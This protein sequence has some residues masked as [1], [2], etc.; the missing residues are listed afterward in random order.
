MTQFSH[1]SGSAADGSSPNTG[2]GVV[3]Y[4]R[5]L[6]SDLNW[7][8]REGSDFFQ[9][10][11][12]V[13]ESLRRITKRLDEIGVYYAIIGGLALFFHGYRR[14][15]QDIDLLV[16]ADGMFRITRFLVGFGYEGVDRYTL[17]DAETGVRIDFVISGSML[18]SQNL[19]GMFRVPDPH[20][21]CEFRNGAR[22]ASLPALIDSK[23][24]AGLRSFRLRHL[25]DVQELIK[26]LD[27]PESLIN[28]LDPCVRATYQKLWKECHSRPIRY[29]IRWRNDSSEAAAALTAMKADGIVIDPEKSFGEDSLYLVTN[30]RTIAEKHGLLDEF[31][32]WDRYAP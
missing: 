1:Q 29:V 11:G 20:D 6:D 13:Q 18:S 10:G 14:F 5:Q 21:I 27:L 12:R 22:L 31:E 26:T 24:V 8:M 17:R 16:T 19:G 23:L 3:P 9:G 15:T 2:A 32:Y 4:E 25:G 7:A 30:D 28:S